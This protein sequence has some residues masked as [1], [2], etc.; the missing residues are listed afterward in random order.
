MPQ[1][2][3]PPVQTAWQYWKPVLMVAARKTLSHARLK[4]LLGVILSILT[5]LFQHVL[6]LRNWSDT[7]KVIASVISAAVVVMLVSL[8]THLLLEPVLLHQE[9]QAMIVTPLPLVT[10]FPHDALQVWTTSHLDVRDSVI[11]MT[12]TNMKGSLCV[13]AYIFSLAGEMVACC[14]CLIPPNSM[15][16][17]SCRNYLISNNLTPAPSYSIIIKLL[18][19]MNPLARTCDPS[20]VDPVTVA[21][22]LLAWG[23]TYGSAETP[24]SSAELTI[25]EL[26]TLT[27]TA[28]FIHN[29]GGGFGICRSCQ[30]GAIEVRQ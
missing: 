17:F 24:F 7:Q 25:A 8:I 18:A 22:G 13:N 10:S 11:T 30:H 19:S 28:R 14:S 20:S 12:N 9:Q 29:N 1:G 2:T 26:N 3:Q 15:A 27:T 23:K 5:F 16:S 4:I 21:S 6:N